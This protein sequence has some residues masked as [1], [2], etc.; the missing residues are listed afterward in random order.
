LIQINVEIGRALILCKTRIAVREAFAVVVEIVPR[1]DVRRLQMANDDLPQSDV[2][3]K[4]ALGLR[5]V[6]P[7]IT[8]AQAE[9]AALQLTACR[10]SSSRDGRLFR[11]VLH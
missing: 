6:F 10:H 9:L 2:V 7:D 3:A 11:H 8:R 1:S 5:G 4:V